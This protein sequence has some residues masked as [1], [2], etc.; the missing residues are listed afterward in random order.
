[1][2]HANPKKAVIFDLGNVVLDWDVNRI[3]GSLNL[4]TEKGKSIK[5]TKN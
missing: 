2:I 3:L 4:E 5:W 1:M